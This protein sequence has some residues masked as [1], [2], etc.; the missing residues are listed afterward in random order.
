MADVKRKSTRQEKAASTR[1][2][3][4]TA[5]YAAFCEDGFKATTM[6]AIARRADV[7]VQTLYFTFHTKDELLQQVHEWTVLGD[8]PTPPP[9]Q[10]WHVAAVAEPDALRSVE[11]IAEGLVT[12]LARVAP[13][14][15]VFQAV[16][17]DPAG[18]VWA[19]GERLRR[20]GMEELVDMLAK[21]RRLRRGVTKRQAG[22][23]LFVLAGPVCYRSFVLEA[24][25]SPTQ[26]SRWV[27]RAL[28]NDLFGTETVSDADHG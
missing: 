22:D 28:R 17:G 6:E 16:A 26:W 7:A 9:M 18:E 5:A 1:R 13:T 4:V 21:K 11:L 15:P 23:V 25:W 2:R 24:G 3:I 14:V 27:S 12:I 20:A 8:D 10:P 19:R